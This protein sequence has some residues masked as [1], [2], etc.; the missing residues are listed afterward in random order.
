MG[1]NLA[2]PTPRPLDHLCDVD[3]S[4]KS[5]MGGQKVLMSLIND[6]FLG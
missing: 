4:W 1:N 6:R 2:P 5:T 3:L